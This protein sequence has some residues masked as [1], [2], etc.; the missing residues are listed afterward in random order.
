MSYQQKYYDFF[1]DSEAGQAFINDLHNIINRQHEDAEDAPETAR[2][3][4]SRAKGV[5]LVIAHINSIS[6]KLKGG[7]A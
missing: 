3:A 2:D 6:A 7:E 5:R 1:M 4:I